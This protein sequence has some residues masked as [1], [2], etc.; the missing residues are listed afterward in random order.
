M[1]NREDYLT[2]AQMQSWSRFLSSPEGKAGMLFLKL[3][4]PRNR[5]KT[6]ASLIKNSVGFEFWQDAI[7]AME[8]LGE[9]PARP[10]KQEDE[11]LE[12]P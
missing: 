1:P 2:R 4:C 10:E 8:K 6:E 12:Q 11:S 5:E 3:A 7:E 9:V